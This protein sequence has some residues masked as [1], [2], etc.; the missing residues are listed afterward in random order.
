MAAEKESDKSVLNSFQEFERQESFA[1]IVLIVAVALAMLWANVSGDTYFFVWWTDLSINF[2]NFSFSEP[3]VLWINDGLMVIF[4]FLVGL[5]IKRELW[6]GELASPRKAALPFF[7]ALGGM[8]VPAG[9]YA[10]HCLRPGNSLASGKPCSH[11]A[12][13]VFDGACNHR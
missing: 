1:G 7:A 8:L 6:R 13:S 10:G 5:E 4:F 11:R 12:E 2:A 3:L 9:I